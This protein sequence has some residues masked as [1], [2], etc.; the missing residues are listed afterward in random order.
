MKIVDLKAREIL[1]S[2][3]F[4][5][6]EV[7][8][9]TESGHLRWAQVPSGAS[10]GEFEALELRDGD[11]SRF[12][13]K[14]LKKAIENINGVIKKRLLGMDILN[15]VVIDRTL[16]ELDGTKNKSRLGAN[17]IL[18]VSLACIK[19]AAHALQLPLYRYI[20][21]T[22]AKTIPVPLF[23]IINGGKHAPNNLDIQE[24]I[25]VPLGAPN[26]AEALRYGAEVYHYLKALLK[27][28]GLNA[29]VADEGGFAPDAK[30]NEAPLEFISQAIEQAGY[31]LGTD[32][33]LALDCAASTFFADNR[34]HLKLDSRSLT[35]EE[36]VRLYEDWANRYHLI[37]IEDGLAEEDW[38]GWQ[39]LT[40][41]LGKK[42]QIV[43]DDIF[44][45]NFE[46]LEKGIELH[47]AT[48][49]LIKPNQIGTVTETLD[50]IELAKKH[51][52]NVVIS[53]RSGE[54]ED[55]FIA[56]LAVATNAH[57]LKSGAPCRAERTAKYNR[58]LRIEEEMGGGFLGV[59]ALRP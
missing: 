7:E 3:A 20:G 37:S 42:I 26:F 19:T 39:L 15:Q 55:T 30:S 50:C 52:Y 21:G 46:R 2:R 58:L 33:F 47:V 32:I 4:P 59:R 44:A 16:I 13:G 14:G 9:L 10:T 24:Y 43:G 1:D 18:G 54:T 8:C 53:H 51:N 38:Q 29:A 36:L 45:T 28:K 35:A 41:R 22:G 11:M 48:A 25:I 12:L 27:G 57:F 34:Y 31:K 56:D 6:L 17:T 40:S 23:N 5:A 49:A